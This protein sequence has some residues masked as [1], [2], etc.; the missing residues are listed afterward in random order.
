[1]NCDE[2]RNLLAALVLDSLDTD[3]RAAVEAHLAACADCRA[4]RE[5]YEAAVHSLPEALAVASPVRLPPELKSRLLERIEAGAEAAH[6]ALPGARRRRRLYAAALA[7]AA[8]LVG[9]LTST[10]V[11]GVAL[12][13]ERDL[14]SKLDG[15]LGKQE[16]VLDIVDAKQT[17]RALLRPAAPGSAAYGKVFTNPDFRSVV[18]LAARLPQPPPGRA[19]HV[20]LTRAGH[21]RLVGVLRVNKEGF[22]L[23]VF[24]AARTGPRYTAA[25]IY[26]QQRGSTRPAGPLVLAWHA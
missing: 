20:W 17:S 21:T 2:T 3:E 6:P 7:G 22:G 8:L 5:A 12:A 23:L 24:D 14:R 25:R 26:L 4:L 9:A 11:L 15:L 1:M 10:A 13:R 18:F 19:Y 16:V